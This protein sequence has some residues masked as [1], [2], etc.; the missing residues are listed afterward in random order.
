MPLK[1]NMSGRETVATGV[2]RFAHLMVRSSRAHMGEIEL[3]LG[4]IIKE[5]GYGGPTCQELISVRE[6]LQAQLRYLTRLVDDL[7]FSPDAPTEP[8]DN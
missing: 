7:H 5:E 8:E 4:K 2:A 1:T 6:S 3:S